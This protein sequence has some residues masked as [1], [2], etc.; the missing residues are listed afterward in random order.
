MRIKEIVEL[1]NADIVT[2]EIYDEIDYRNE[3]YFG[4]ELLVAPITSPK[5]LVMNRSVEEIFL[6]EGTWYDF[7]TGKKFLGNQKYILFFKD[8]DYPVF[9]QNGTIICLADLE[10]NLN[11]TDPPKTM[12]IHVF[13]CK[14]NTY[15]L[16]EDDGTTNMYQQGN[17]LI[18]KIDYNYLKNNYTLIIRPVEGKSGI[19][20]DLRNYR[21]RFRNTRESN[22]VLVYI[23]NEQVKFSTLAD[24]NDFIVEVKDVPTTKQL[25]INCKG[26]DIEIDATR[27]IN[28][29]IDSII[30][31]LQI[32]TVIKEKLSEIIFSDNK[33]EQK[34]IM[35][36]KLKREGLE[37]KFINM[38]LK[39]LEYVAQI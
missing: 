24:D 1:L 6:P 31:D 39:L 3:Y 35:I 20:P 27:I 13:P 5:K 16:Y 25:T 10:E 4:S 21:I 36:R 30:S 19:I 28:E 7:K 22:E 23:D 26:K 18:T 14:N 17:Y 34:R 38:F 2:P 33:F 11:L 9:A 32:K 37:S 8:D 12:E 29:D 15:N